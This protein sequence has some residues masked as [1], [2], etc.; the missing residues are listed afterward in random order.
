MASY[1]GKLNGLHRCLM[2]AGGRSRFWVPRETSR[3]AYRVPGHLCSNG[4]LLA[5]EEVRLNA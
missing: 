3:G 5:L 2:A 4:V 1:K